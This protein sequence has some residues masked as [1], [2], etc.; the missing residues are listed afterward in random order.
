[1][2]ILHGVIIVFLIGSSFI[3][4]LPKWLDIVIVPISLIAI[5]GFITGYGC[6]LVNLENYFRQ[7]AQ[8]EIVSGSF[9]GHYIEQIFNIS[10]SIGWCMVITVL[11]GIGLTWITI[12]LWNK[13]VRQRAD[14]KDL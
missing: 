5:G 6:V 12:V 9:I 13:S 8:Q 2:A 11:I 1:V 4:K 10:L 14:L 3:K 7:L